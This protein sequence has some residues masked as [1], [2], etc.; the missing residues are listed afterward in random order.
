MAMELRNDLLTEILDIIR[1]ARA[2]VVN[3][4]DFERTLMY[5]KIG[6]RFFE[7]E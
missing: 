7:E 5:W 2:A 3:S 1:G 4:V 6:Q